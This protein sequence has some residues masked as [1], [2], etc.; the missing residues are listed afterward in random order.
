MLRAASATRGQKQSVSSRPPNFPTSKFPLKYNL[1]D[2]TTCIFWKFNVPSSL[3]NFHYYGNKITCLRKFR[4]VVTEI[5]LRSNAQVAPVTT[6]FIFRRHAFVS[7]L[8]SLFVA[9]SF[10][11]DCPCFSKTL[12]MVFENDGQRF[13]I[14]R[15]T[16]FALTG[17]RFLSDRT[18]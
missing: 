11:K 16:N 10:K 14:G 9:R 13:S 15:A 18:A 3:K 4:H 2:R 7:A 1:P 5:L 12:P 8:R 17:N 6:S